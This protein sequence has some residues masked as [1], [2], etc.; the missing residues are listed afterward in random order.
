MNLVVRASGSKALS[1]KAASWNLATFFHVDLEEVAQVV[2]AGRG[3][4]EVALLLNRC[5]LGVTL[6]DDD[7]PQVGAVLAGH[8]GPHSL[9]FMVI[10]L[11]LLR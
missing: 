1:D 8:I 4:P 6:R 10:E 5:R 2:H 11:H 3:Q 7:A 9:A